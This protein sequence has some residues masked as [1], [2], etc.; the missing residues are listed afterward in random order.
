M[1]RQLA[2]SALAGLT[3]VSAAPPAVLSQIRGDTSVAVTRPMGRETAGRVPAVDWDEAARIVRA[4]AAAEMDGSTIPAL[5][6]QLSTRL[7]LA[8]LV[9]SMATVVD[10]AGQSLLVEGGVHRTYAD[11]VA[12]V[13]DKAARTM[14]ARFEKNRTQLDQLRDRAVNL[15]NYTSEVLNCDL[16]TGTCPADVADLGS[17]LI[18]QINAIR[19]LLLDA[20]AVQRDLNNE[21]VVASS[22]G[23]AFEAEMR[24]IRLRVLSPL[25][26]AVQRLGWTIEQR[27][28]QTAVR[29]GVL[30]L[31]AYRAGTDSLESTVHVLDSMLN[32]WRQ[33]R[34]GGVEFVQIA[35]Q[36]QDLLEVVD[37]AIAEVDAASIDEDGVGR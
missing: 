12:I 20:A 1:L 32:N 19:D 15:T 37:Q 31:A 10:S 34:P 8:E 25:K 5:E 17:V 9:W 29:I 22:I 26:R 4:A 28:R 2:W 13:V 6:H 27:A 24:A 30:R 16:A 33:Q 23:S 7:D 11:S 21:Y 36:L 3:L 18:E 14:R 35:S